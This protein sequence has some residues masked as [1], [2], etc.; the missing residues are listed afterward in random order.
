MT[1]LAGVLLALA[2]AFAVTDWLGVIHSD[3]RLRWVGK[4]GTMVLLL[5]VAVALHPASDTQRNLFLTALL[6]SLFGDVYLLLTGERWFA[7][8]LAAF[9]AAHLAYAAG[10]LAGGVRPGLLAITAPVVALVSIAAGGR[11]LVPLRRSARGRLLAPVALYLLAISAM[12]ALAAAS[13]HPL[14]LAGAL[15]FYVSDGLIAW[16][17]FVRPLSWSPLPTIAT[18][19]L[20]QGL[21]VISLAG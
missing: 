3:R 9:L 16:N 4:P 10:F 15:L 8:G 21:L 12:V 20:A 19:H 7:A 13:G 2:G 1:P 5:A 18:Y 17:R 14:A 6:L 11:I